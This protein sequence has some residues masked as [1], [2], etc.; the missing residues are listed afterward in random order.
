[1]KVVGICGS[2]KKENSTT[3]FGLE[4]AMQAVKGCG[5]DTEIVQLSHHSFSGCIDC[6]KCREEY[7]CSLNDDFTNKIMPLLKGDEIKGLILGSPVYFGGVSS[8]MKMFIDR[9]VLFRRNGFRF[10]NL[11]AGVLTVGRSRNGGQELT[12]MDLVKNAMIQGMTVVSDASPTSHFGGVFWS[13]NPGGVEQDET[14]IKT[15]QNLGK[16]VGELVIKVF[17]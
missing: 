3:L 10:E 14:G 1:M 15:A 5:V 2:P 9:C 13:G 12:A 6:G 16:R 8:Q 11:I 4:K 17:G 7:T